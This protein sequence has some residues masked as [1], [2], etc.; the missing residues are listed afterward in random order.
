MRYRFGIV[1]NIETGRNLPFICDLSE[2]Y[3]KV[4]SLYI[5]TKI[6]R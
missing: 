5:K 1:T 6:S 2:F 3:G 4:D